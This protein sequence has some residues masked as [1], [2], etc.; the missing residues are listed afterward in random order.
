MQATFVELIHILSNL[1]RSV[2]SSSSSFSTFDAGYLTYRA[3]LSSARCLREN[4]LLFVAK[5][6]V[7]TWSIYI[8]RER[9]ITVE[10]I[11]PPF[12][13]FNWA[14]ACLLDCG[15]SILI[16]VYTHMLADTKCNQINVQVFFL[17]IIRS[18][19]KKKNSLFPY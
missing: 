1:M 13:I 12:A 5:S 6:T 17:P 9:G 15:K 8:E 2:P 19:K 14:E 7:R 18:K 4:P 16:V 10:I 3:I 11:V